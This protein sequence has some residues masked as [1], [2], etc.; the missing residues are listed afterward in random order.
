M[1]WKWELIAEGVSRISAF[2]VGS[3]EQQEEEFN[4]R[5]HLR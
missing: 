4:A 3:G 5:P 2:L 1:K